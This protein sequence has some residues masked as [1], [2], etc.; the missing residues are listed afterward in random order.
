MKAAARLRGDGFE[1]LAVTGDVTSYEDVQAMA[2]AVE[3]GLGP[4]DVLVNNAG[5]VE[6]R[7][8]LEVSPEG[9]GR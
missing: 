4:I 7:P 2:A 9:G 5:V 3:A 6:H 1:V 8:A